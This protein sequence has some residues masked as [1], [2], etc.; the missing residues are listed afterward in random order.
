MSFRILVS[1]CVGLFLL[2]FVLQAF[3]AI[4]D[5]LATM[6]RGIGLA[7]GVTGVLMLV[8]ELAERIFLK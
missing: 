2:S 7:F 6:L 3:F 5:E 4:D 8:I 1:S